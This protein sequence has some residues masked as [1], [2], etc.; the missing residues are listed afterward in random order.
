[1]PHCDTPSSRRY[2]IL[3]LCPGTSFSHPQAH[4]KSVSYTSNIYV[5]DLH[6][7]WIWPRSP[8][9]QRFQGSIV[10]AD[11]AVG[12]AHREKHQG[13][14]AGGEHLLSSPG[15]GP[16]NPLRLTCRRMSREHTMKKA[17]A[18]IC[19]AKVKENG[20]RCLFKEPTRGPLLC[21]D[22]SPLQRNSGC[23]PIHTHIQPHNH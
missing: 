6:G 4:M 16:C 5:Y 1:M 20:D 2:S 15:P 7:S 19:K 21:G 17:N 18:H 22:F 14:C 10:S 3:T 13:W 11:G 8:F 12:H 9:F 23:F